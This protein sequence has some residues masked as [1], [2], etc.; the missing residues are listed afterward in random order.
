VVDRLGIG[1][2]RPTQRRP[3]SRGANG[4]RFSSGIPRAVWLTERMQRLR[5]R[6]MS[7]LGTWSIGVQRS[8]QRRAWSETRRKQPLLLYEGLKQ[9]RAGENRHTWEAMHTWRRRGASIERW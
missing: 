3:H 9:I 7:V 5:A 4:A 8:E 6:S 2:G 1:D